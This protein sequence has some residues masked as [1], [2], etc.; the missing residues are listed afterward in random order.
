[1]KTTTILKIIIFL[2]ALGLLMSL[3]LLDNHYAG[4]AQGSVCD[5]GET[6][7]CSLVNSSVYS[8]LWGVP[9]AL[10]GVM[11]F[12]FVL[13]LSWK[14]QKKKEL[15]PLLLGWSIVGLLSIIYFLHAEIILRALCPFCTTVHV[16]IVII[17]IFLLRA[18]H[19][20]KKVP[21]ARAFRIAKL[22]IG[23]ILLMI[24]LL[25]VLF[26]IS[27]GA[28]ENYDE[29]AKCLTSKGVVMYGSF[30]CGVCAK[31]RAM[32]GDSFQYIHEIECHPQGKNSQYQLCLDKKIT[33]TPTWMIE[34]NGS[35][36][37]RHTGFLSISE[38][39]QFSGCSS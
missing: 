14:A 28:K 38:L 30:R 29:L 15:I 6:I 9:V 19:Q 5:F 1:M 31:T 34:G 12:V 36:L 27:F 18:Y 24:L 22:W 16:L 8:E 37:Q 13:L 39:Q 21:A 10:L 2:S 35:E 4:A 32:F 23:V 11:W 33:G 25:F 17:F 7:S 26:T 20:E 3:Y